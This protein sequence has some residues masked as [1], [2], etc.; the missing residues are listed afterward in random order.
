MKYDICSVCSRGNYKFKTRKNQCEIKLPYPA[1][2][3]E[4]KPIVIFTGFSSYDCKYCLRE[5]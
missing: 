5:K 2:T 1:K 3:E 4:G